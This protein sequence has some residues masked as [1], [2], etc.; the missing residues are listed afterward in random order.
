MLFGLNN[1]YLVHLLCLRWMSLM[2]LRSS[3]LRSNHFN[4]GLMTLNNRYQVSPIVRDFLLI[5][6]KHFQATYQSLPKSMKFTDLHHLN[7]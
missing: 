6:D 7:H 4:F 3:S 1:H 5:F 2:F